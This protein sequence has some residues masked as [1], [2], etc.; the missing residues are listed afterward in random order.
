MVPFQC[1]VAELVVPTPHV[2]MEKS[3]S[4]ID[5]LQKTENRTQ[6]T[7]HRTQKTEHRKQK[8]EHRKQNT[9]HRKQK[10]E[11]KKYL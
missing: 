2:T 8:T 9:E 6:N 4:H 10:T 11:K 3:Q 7:E 5:I 1:S